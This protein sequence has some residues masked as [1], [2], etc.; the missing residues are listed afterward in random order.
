M[1]GPA[2]PKVRVYLVEDQSLIR[3]VLRTRLE[4]EDDIEVIGEAGDAET[5]LRELP[6][7][8]VNVVLMDIGLPGIDGLEATKQLKQLKPDVSVLILTSYEDEHVGRA[9][10][11]GASG[12]ILK[13]ATSEQLTES[14]MAVHEGQAFLDP[15]LTGRL[16]EQV[17]ESRESDRKSR[18][19]ERQIEIL[20]LVA[21]GVRYRDI[22]GE[23]FISETTVNREAR[24]IFNSLGVNDAAHAVAE[25]YRLGILHD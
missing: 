21:N 11:A 6:F 18:L 16:F 23:L 15:S 7:V 12:Y 2:K 17:A 13:K 4:F 10:D 1:A 14:V 8:D 19:T 3:E 5:A 20:K 9:I 25:A 24:A 22:A